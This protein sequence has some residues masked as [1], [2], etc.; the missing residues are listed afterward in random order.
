MSSAP[1]LQL[2]RPATWSRSQGFSSLIERLEMHDPRLVRTIS[3]PRVS[4]QHQERLPPALLSNSGLSYEELTWAA[5]FS[6]QAQLKRL[7]DLLVAATL[8]LLTAPFITLFC[9]SFDLARRS[10]CVL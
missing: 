3:V 2:F 5:P 7:A 4:F 9:C 10:C 8:L 6:V 1:H